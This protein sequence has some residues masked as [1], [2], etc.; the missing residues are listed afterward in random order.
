[1]DLTESLDGPGVDMC[2]GADREGNSGGEWRL[3]EE[4]VRRPDLLDYWDPSQRKVERISTNS[5]FALATGKPHWI[6]SA[7]PKLSAE[8]IRLVVSSVRSKKPLPACAKSKL[9]KLGAAC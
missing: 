6:Q 9:P 4:V 3:L 5:L 1:M 8:A 7:A 2:S